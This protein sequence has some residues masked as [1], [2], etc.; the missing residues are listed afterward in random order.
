MN[1]NRIDLIRAAAEKSKS[2]SVTQTR[3]RHPAS[4]AGQD[5][6]RGKVRYIIIGHEQLPCGQVW[7]ARPSHAKDGTGDITLTT[8]EVEAEVAKK[9]ARSHVYEKPFSG[10]VHV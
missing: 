5:F 9:L 1:R 8:E 6:K 10:R 7:R 2:A 3:P 4:V